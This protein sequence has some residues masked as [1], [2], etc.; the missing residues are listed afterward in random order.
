MIKE[1]FYAANWYRKV[2][3]GKKKIPLQTVLFIN[4]ECNLQCVHCNVYKLDNPIVKSYKQIEEEL[5]YSYRLGSRFVDFEGGE[6]LLWR[7]GDYSLNDLLILAKKIG[8]F[9][10]TV[11]TNAQLPFAHIQP[12]SIWVSMDGLEEYH[13]AV[14]GVGAFEKLEKNIAGSN[15][16]SLS[17]NM[18]IN[19]KNYTNVE[20]TIKY[21]KNNPHIRSISF[22]FYTPYDDKKLLFLDWELRAQVIDTIIYM[23]KKGYPI[24]N[25]MSGL[26]LMKGNDFKK[27]CWITNFILPD[28]SRLAE[29]PGKK[30][31]I[32]DLCGFC[33]AGEMYSVFNF[34]FDTLFAGIK[35]R[36]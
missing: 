16:K 6:P 22:N 7:D 20:E 24:M 15:H 34:K 21:V 26:K 32:C 30:A 27:C 8:F 4:E 10:T 28:G 11:T 18:V 25:S 12:D 9:S 19:S 17:V 1:L 31:G 14:R 23:K 36:F 5:L 29:C 35:L 13:D 3:F 2:K 33:M